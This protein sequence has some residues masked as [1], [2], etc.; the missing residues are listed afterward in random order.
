MIRSWLALTLFAFS[1]PL[2]AQL[3]SGDDAVTADHYIRDD[4]FVFMHTGPSREYRILGSINAGTAI[5][6]L[7]RDGE[8][9]QITDEDERTGWV[10]SR[11][12]SD[13]LPVAKQLP[14]LSQQL[15]DSQSAL[16][17]AE[18]ESARLR[19][20]LNDSRQ[21]IAELSTAVE[22]KDRKVSK[23]TTQ[24]ERADQDELVTWFTRGGMV[25]GAGI[26]LGIIIAY[27]P[28]KRKRDN[29]WM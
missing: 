2:F 4:L 26:L 5:E 23:L 6:V 17:E 8:F 1:L 24:V 14:R 27:L 7:E 3:D 18:S 22:E 13:T 28:K 16:A 21:Q 10:E 11:Y 9:T 12:V 20:Q 29:Q 25:A 15:A 19:Q